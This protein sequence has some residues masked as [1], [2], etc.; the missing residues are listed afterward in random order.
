MLGA[1]LV[2]KRGGSIIR[3]IF[4]LALVLLLVKIIYDL[5]AGH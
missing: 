2:I 1:K 3:P 4:I 5:L